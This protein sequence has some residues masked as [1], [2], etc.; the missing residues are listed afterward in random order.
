MGKE[1]TR[2]APNNRT[3]NAA[4]APEPYQGALGKVYVLDTNILM[5]SPYSIFAFDE[6][7]VVICDTTLEELDGLKS[8]PGERGANAREAIRALEALRQDG[9]LIINTPTGAMN[10]G[11]PLPGGGHCHIYCHTVSLECASSHDKRTADNEI[12]LA[13]Q[14]IAS[15]PGFNSKTVIL[16]TNDINMR[17]KAEAHCIR[18]EEYKTEQSAHLHDQYR[19]RCKVL[20]TS[21]AINSFYKNKQLD[22]TA[23]NLRVEGQED[24]R[25]TI[26]EFV[27]LV[28][29][30]HERNSALARFDGNKFV[31]LSCESKSPYGVRP[32][33][34][35]QK[36]AQ[37]AL[38]AA[39]ESAPLVIL[40]GPAGTAKTFYSLAAGLEQVLNNNESGLTRILVARPNIKFDEDIGFLKGTE[41]EK[42]GPLIRPVFDN[43]EQL[44]RTASKKDGTNISSYAQDLFDRGI[45]TA[46]ALAYMRGR[47]ITNTWIIIDEAQ[48]MTPTQAFGI[49][50]R[51]G[52][53]SK[54]ILAGDPEQIDSP[55]LDA[56][57]NGLSYA[58]EK[59]KGSP[60]CWQVSFDDNECVRSALALAAI[61]RMSPKGTD[62]MR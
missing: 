49:V 7:D 45:V 18:A 58:S 2:K 44:T 12:L 16:V 40:K 59:M 53:G 3:R 5:S 52:E 28:E 26:N 8:A 38:L 41:E 24:Y 43:F 17:I 19:G 47:S 20:T 6:H 37:E 57:T 54:I 42:I 4:R 22:P 15:V 30:G 25:F 27:L 39:V 48:N 10:L 13:C 23:Y 21:D 14:C 55:H 9:S 11:K 29:E 62:H 46:Q 36:F 56:R 61:Q 35:G 51:C 50:S 31:P 60:L 32:R 34:V 1:N 33:N